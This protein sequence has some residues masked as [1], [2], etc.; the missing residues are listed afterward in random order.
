MLSKEKER[1]DTPGS[2]SVTMPSFL[3]GSNAQLLAGVVQASICSHD[4]VKYLQAPTSPMGIAI[5]QIPT[6]WPGVGGEMLDLS[7]RPAVMD[8]RKV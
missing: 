5:K 8:V 2:P 1:G 3:N 7:K 4:L 6:L